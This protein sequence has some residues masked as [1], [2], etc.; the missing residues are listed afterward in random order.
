MTTTTGLFLRGCVVGVQLVFLV[1][2]IK[3][4]NV[5]IGLLWAL[6]AITLALPGC[7]GPSFTS[8]TAARTELSDAA[9]DASD[10][11]ATG[12]SSA[13][14]TTELATGGKLATGGS[15]STGGSESTGG[16]SSAPNLNACPC[17]ES[18]E[19]KPKGDSCNA[20]RTKLGPI[21]NLVCISSAER[22]TSDGFSVYCFEC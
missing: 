10:D 4:D 17:P 12:G 13:I 3:R 21:G 8:S 9:V 16:A 7:S 6:A 14:E 18:P 22:C 1:R 5:P 19:C 20:D 11:E 2:G 15:S